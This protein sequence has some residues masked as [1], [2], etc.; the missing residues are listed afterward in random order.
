MHPRTECAGII[1]GS[2]FATPARRG[3]DLI[4]AGESARLQQRRGMIKNI[5][6]QLCGAASARS[7]RRVCSGGESLVF[8]RPAGR[9]QRAIEKR[10]VDVGKP[11]PA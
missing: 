2:W 3:E 9:D 1:A 8:G 6:T 4:A 11:P 7:V 10:R 5:G